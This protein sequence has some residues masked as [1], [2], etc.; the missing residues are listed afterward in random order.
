[1]EK[2]VLAVMAAGI[3]SRYKGLKQIDPIGKNGEIIIDFSLYDAL[4]AGFRK[5][6]FIIKKELEESF[7]EII[8]DKVSRF[9]AVEYAFQELDDLPEGYLLPA[10]REKPWGT[11]H[12]VLA[13]RNIIKGPF[14]VI[15]AD[16]YY[17]RKA[18]QLIYEYLVNTQDDDKYRYA[19]V[20]YTLENTITEFGHV[21]RGVCVV[22]NEG[23]LESINERTHIEKRDGKTQYTEDGENWVTIPSGSI[24]SM[25]FWGFTS[26]F[27][28]EL[29]GKFPLFLDKALKENPLKG[30]Y[31]LPSVVDSLLKEGKATVKVLHT[32]DKWY[33]VTYREDKPLVAAALTHMQ[34][35]GVYPEK[36]WE[37]ACI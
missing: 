31:F 8:G 1:M 34:E 36:L 16:D 6:V 30:E 23:Y 20:G 22:N 33:G 5:V 7:R 18:F 11:G 15:N 32:P 2:P 17:G 21:A 35:S 10:G 4:Q 29:E 9:M 26:S 12:A 28:K 13:C 27:L 3:G 25:N 19:M 24:V 14:A 37:D